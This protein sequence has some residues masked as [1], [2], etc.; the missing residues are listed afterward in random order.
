LTAMMTGTSNIKHILNILWGVVLLVSCQ[1]EKAE[2]LESRI[3]PT[4]ILARINDIEIINDSLWIACAGN[5]ESQ[6]YFL[7]SLDGG[8]SWSH[9]SSPHPKS[10]YCIDFLP[11]G[12]GIAG[13]DFLDLW[14][15]HDFGQ[16]WNFY[17]LGSQVP[18]NEEDR[19]GVRDI[20]LVNDSVWTFCGGE[21][22]GEGVIYRT[23]NSGQSWNFSFHQHEFRSTAM[24]SQGEIVTAGHGKVISYATGLSD[25]QYSGFKD[26]F[27]TGL[28][29][30]DNNTMVACTFEGRIV[31]SKD[32]GMNWNETIDMNRYFRKRINWNDVICEGSYCT[33]VG[34]DGHLAM[35]YDYGVSWKLLKIQ[36]EKNL[37]SAE[38]Y[39]N[40]IIA[41]DSEGNIH[42]IQIAD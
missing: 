8:V 27:I 30:A 13:G 2:T 12:F 34:T 9:V 38:I 1:K 36:E 42:F 4:G 35:S 19:P 3:V 10:I 17:W 11:N 7:Q 20:L 41:G 28:S 22:L 16:N 40:K 18:F 32:G 37:I 39:S 23:T 29:A 33:C 31:N 21:N 5:R 6:G 24:S 26:G 25:I 14:I 15:T